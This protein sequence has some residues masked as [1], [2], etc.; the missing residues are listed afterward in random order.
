M[1]VVLAYF[2]WPWT[3]SS[4]LCINGLGATKN[5]ISESPAV[6]ESDSPVFVEAANLAARKSP[7]GGYLFADMRPRKSA[8][9]AALLPSISI[10]ADTVLCIAEKGFA[11][12]AKPVSPKG[13]RPAGIAVYGV[14]A[15]GLGVLDGDVL[16]EVLGQPV[17]SQAQVVALVMVARGANKSTISGTL[18]RGMRAYSVSVQQPYEFPDCSAEQ[19]EC[20]R[21]KCKDE[22]RLHH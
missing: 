19:S 11:P 5:T 18:W 14:S 13:K 7:G 3:A 17:R 9:S 12:T 2:A 20:W 16:T 6:I 15:L 10:D 8:R 21:S 1:A 4:W 22:E